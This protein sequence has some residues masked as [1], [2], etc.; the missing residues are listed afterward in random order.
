ML[1][2]PWILKAS[3]LG[4]ATMEANHLMVLIKP[5]VGT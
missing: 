2:T 3:R 5:L 1:Q 4:A